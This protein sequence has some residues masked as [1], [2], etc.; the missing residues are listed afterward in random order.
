MVESNNHEQLGTLI[1]LM[2][3]RKIRETEVSDGSIVPH[4]SS[5]HIKDL[6]IRIAD[7]SKWRN[8]QRRGSEA[9]A[10]YSRLI[11]RLKSELVSARRSSEKVKL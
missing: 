10:N 7:L 6:E 11:S 9:R 4:G 8:K 3:E 1:D 2:V 5:K